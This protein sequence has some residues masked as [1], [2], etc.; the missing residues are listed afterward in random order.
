[1]EAHGNEDFAV[2][3]ILSIETTFGEEFQGKVI[4]FDRP[5][6]ILVIQEGTNSVAGTKMNIRLLK[7]NYIKEFALLGQGEDPLDASKCFLDLE[8]LKSREDSAIRQAELDAERFGVGV[9][10]EAQSIFDALAKTLPVRWEKTVIVVMNEV[11]VSSPYLPESVK[12][13]TPA[14]NERVRKVLEFERKRL[15][16]RN[17][18]Q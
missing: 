7:A 1:M 8:T 9:T 18:G 6:N 2:G 15:Q 12:G 14:A 16:A 5:S 11:R 10:P 4:T 13:G 17:A 3:C